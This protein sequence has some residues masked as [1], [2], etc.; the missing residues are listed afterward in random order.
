MKCLTISDSYELLKLLKL[1][2]VYVPLFSAISS[3]YAGHT[4][5]YFT[6]DDSETDQADKP[7][8][9]R[10]DVS[11]AYGHCKTS[12]YNRPPCDKKVLEQHEKIA[13]KRSSRIKQ[14]LDEK[15]KLDDVI[16]NLLTEYS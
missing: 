10:S 6:T 13:T 8:G 3:S 5:S 14:L 1:C 15:K 12:R 4:T 16:K 2:A 11:N 9:K 7:S